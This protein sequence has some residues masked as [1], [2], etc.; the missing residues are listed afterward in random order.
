L[1]SVTFQ[2]DFVCL[3][4]TRKNDDLHPVGEPDDYTKADDKMSG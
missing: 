1:A 3:N 4:G 2:T